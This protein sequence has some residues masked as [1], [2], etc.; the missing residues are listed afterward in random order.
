[1]LAI[2]EHLTTAFAEQIITKIITGNKIKHSQTSIQM[3]KTKKKKLKEKLSKN[4]V[5]KNKRLKMKIV[6]IYLVPILL[7]THL[8]NLPTFIVYIIVKNNCFK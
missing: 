3:Q 8:Q 1:M 6:H 2:H 4:L 5:K 7:H